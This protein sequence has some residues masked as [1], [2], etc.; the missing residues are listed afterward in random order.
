MDSRSNFIV[1]IDEASAFAKTL[2]AELD[3]LSLMANRSEQIEGDR[4]VPEGEH[5]RRQVSLRGAC[6][7]PAKTERNHR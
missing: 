6:P 1:A 5:A 2:T 7:Q 3:A 4:F